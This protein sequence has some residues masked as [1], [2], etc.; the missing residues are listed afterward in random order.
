[1]DKFKSKNGASVSLVVICAV[2]INKCRIQC[3]YGH[4]F[5][6]IRARLRGLNDLL[7]LYQIIIKH[8]ISSLANAIAEPR[9]DLNIK[10]AAF[11]VIQKLYNT[12][13][14]YLSITCVVQYP[15]LLKGNQ[16]LSCT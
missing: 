6:E 7:T 9:P 16:M 2:R 4:D 11:T 14:F 3:I 1:M 8:D 15:A 5:H 10:F 12:H 13:A